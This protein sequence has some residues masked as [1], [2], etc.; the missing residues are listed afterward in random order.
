MNAPFTTNLIRSITDTPRVRRVKHLVFSAYLLACG[1]LLVATAHFSTL[2][3]LEA[4]EKLHEKT[5]MEISF[6]L[7]YPDQDDRG[8]YCTAL[9]EQ[10]A[11]SHETL[12]L[13]SNGL[14]ARIDTA[15]ILL[16]LALPLPEG[17]HIMNCSIDAGSGKLKLALVVPLKTFAGQR[18]P[19]A[20]LIAQ[21]SSDPVLMT[22]ISN[23][24][25]VLSERLT[26]SGE[27]AFVYR[28]TCSLLKGDA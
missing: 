15:G 27:E 25:S 7:A 14:G 10:L 20:P 28:F 1:I 16:G 17:L 11:A 23:I 22:K 9:E 18:P 26:I 24:S 2:R 5:D 6:D 21:W 12:Q 3:L 19:P 4:R 8:Q 13:I